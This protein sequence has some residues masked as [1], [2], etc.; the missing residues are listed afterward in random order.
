M[1]RK[2]K[3]E[4]ENIEVTD[5]DVDAEISRLA[6]Q[7]GMPADDVKKALGNAEMIKE[8]VKIQKALNVLVDNRKKAE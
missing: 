8:D 2:V 7:F 4:E 5:A 6:E 1:A 3:T